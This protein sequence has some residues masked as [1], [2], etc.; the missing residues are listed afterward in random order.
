MLLIPESHLDQWNSDYDNL[1]STIEISRTS[2]IAH[3]AAAW[4]YYQG[5]IAAD[6]FLDSKLE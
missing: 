6:C 3:C 1:P 2:F 4:G 5:L